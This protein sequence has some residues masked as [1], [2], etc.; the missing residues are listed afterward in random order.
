MQFPDNL[1]DAKL[2]EAALLR[3]QTVDLPPRASVDAKGE[4]IDLMGFS[5]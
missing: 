5:G 4:Y 1:R 3:A 2:L